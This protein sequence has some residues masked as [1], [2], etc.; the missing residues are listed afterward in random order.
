MTSAGIPLFRVLPASLLQQETVVPVF[1]F[2]SSGPDPGARL[3][4]AHEISLGTDSDWTADSHD[5]IVRGRLESIAGLAALFGTVGIAG[6]DGRLQLALEWTSAESGWRKLGAPAELRLADCSADVVFPALSLS[7]EAGAIRGVGKIALQVFLGDAGSQDSLTGGQATEPG[8]RF[9]AL[10]QPM[11][12]VA[13]GDSSLFPI[14]EE[15]LGGDEALW[16]FRQCWIDPY[17][18]TFSSEYVSLVLNRDHPHFA[19]LRGKGE[20]GVQSPLMRQVLASWLALFVGETARELN[21]GF[22]ELVGGSDSAHEG[23]IADVAASFVGYGALET[24]S[25]AELAASTQRWLDR[26][27]NECEVPE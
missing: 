3:V 14:S 24:G 22:S 4:A 16:H 17:V 8:F 20:A 19:Q 2:S 5:L 7:L 10:G 21:G 6:L 1:T 9:G 27:L 15:S 23:S 18:D 13:D 26:R 11:T 12:V 25:P